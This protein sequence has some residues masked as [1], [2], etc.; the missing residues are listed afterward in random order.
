MATHAMKGTAQRLLWAAAMLAFLGL[1]SGFYLPGVAP[2]KY[3]YGEK[4]MVK[5]N[6][7]TSENTPLQVDD[8]AC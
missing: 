4:M 5:V 1:S 3:R 8:P 7:M 2:R 6:T